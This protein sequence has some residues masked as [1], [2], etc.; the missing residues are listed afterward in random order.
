MRN[1]A[2]NSAVRYEYSYAFYKHNLK[3]AS[4]LVNDRNPKKKTKRKQRKK[5][6]I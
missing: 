1:I 5:N 2:E 6:T 3:Q 4:A